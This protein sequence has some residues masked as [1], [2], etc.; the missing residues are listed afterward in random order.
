[1]RFLCCPAAAHTDCRVSWYDVLIIDYDGQANATD[2]L[3]AAT[4]GGTT[5]DAMKA[6]HT[7]YVQPARVLNPQGGAGVLDVLPSCFDVS[8]LE[9][10]LS[11]QPDRVTRFSTV[12]DKYRDKYDVVIV[13]T[14]PALGLLTI[15]ALYAAD[16]M[17]IAVQPQYMAVKGLLQLNDA[18]TTVSTNRGVP[19]GVYVLFTQYDRRK[20]LHRL[21]VE[22]VTGAGFRTFDT[23]I[24]DNVALGEAPAVGVDIF[25]YAPRSNGAQDY[26]ALTDEYLNAHKLRHLKHGYK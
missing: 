22:Q 20:S 21:T 26:D 23:K 10:E 8:A 13:D 6:K 24:R 2:A 4:S 3:R 16:E 17:I 25:R 19:V 7:P 15:S 11:T 5:Y 9:S 14:P 1:M 12:A 18:V